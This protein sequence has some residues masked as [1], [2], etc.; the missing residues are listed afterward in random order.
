MIAFEHASSTASSILSISSRR[1]PARTAR[2]ETTFPERHSVAARATPN[3][4]CPNAPRSVT[5]N[6]NVVAL[7]K[8]RDSVTRRRHVRTA[9]LLAGLLAGSFG[10]RALA[11]D[12]AARAAITADDLK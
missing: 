12:D 1:K 3:P 2:S 8:E 10:A 5:V 11:A 7:R 4:G 6:V 9:L